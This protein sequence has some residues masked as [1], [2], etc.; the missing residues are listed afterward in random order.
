MQ[1]S[2]IIQAPLLLADFDSIIGILFVV[3][4]IVAW[5]LKLVASHAQKGPPATVRPKPANRGGDDRLQEEIDI[6][7]KE[8]NPK[9][10]SRRPPAAQPPVP[11]KAN[12]SR[13]PPLKSA[14]ESGVPA[15]ES[16][17][18]K[19]GQSISQRHI[20]TGEKLGE[21]V[22]QHLQQ[23]MRE[24][25]AREAAVFVGD[26][27]D[28]SVEQHLGQPTAPGLGNLAAA[29]TPGA[30]KPHRLVESLRNPASLRQGMVL[31]LILGPPPGRQRMAQQV[32]PDDGVTQ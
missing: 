14:T 2:A 13:K 28:Q 16:K 21:G 32:R 7:I 4:W 24:R 11:V 23:H 1:Y 20:P 3:F 25:V 10:T 27:V 17:R 19:P 31:S 5:V 29:P 22:Q 8:V 9:K 30:P 15:A 6:F 18:S 12:R 26:S